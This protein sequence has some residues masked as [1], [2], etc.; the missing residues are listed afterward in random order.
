MP[1]RK[2]NMHNL[3]LNVYTLNPFQ[4]CPQKKKI[5]FY[6]Y[7]NNFITQNLIEHTKYQDQL[8]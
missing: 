7:Q 1:E 2:K 4:I 8:K 3:A 5:I 6:K